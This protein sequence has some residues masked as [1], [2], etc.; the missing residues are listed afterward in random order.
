MK[1]TRLHSFSDRPHP[2]C[3]FFWL[4]LPSKYASNI[5]NFFLKSQLLQL[6]WPSPPVCFPMF[7]ICSS[8]TSA[9]QHKANITFHNLSS[10]TVLLCLKHYKGSLFHSEEKPHCCKSLCNF[11]S[12]RDPVLSPPISPHLCCVCS[13]NIGL[14]AF[15]NSWIC[16]CFSTLC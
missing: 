13:R 1:T 9:S 12:L 11:T 16:F 4:A 2:I 15:E 7:H 10:V 14:F 5:N 6:L 3:Q 8:S